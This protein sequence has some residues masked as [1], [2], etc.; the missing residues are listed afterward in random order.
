M[1]ILY[2]FR[3]NRV[4]LLNRVPQSLILFK[5]DFDKS[6]EMFLVLLEHFKVRKKCLK[7]LKII[8]SGPEFLTV[9]GGGGNPLY[10][11]TIQ[12]SIKL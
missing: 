5:T 8:E 11:K 2:V 1:Q 10:S 9:S 6:F 7:K 12:N 3:E 4:R